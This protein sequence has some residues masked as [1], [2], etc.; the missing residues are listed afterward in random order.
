METQE[1]K[2]EITPPGLIQALKEG[3]NTVANHIGLILLPVLLDIFIW[4]GPRLRLEQLLTPMVEQMTSTL[5][6]VNTADMQ[7]MVA[8]ATET[9]EI[10]LGQLNLTN[11]LSTFPIGLPSLMKGI[12]TNQSP[13]GAP[14]MIEMPTFFGTVLTFLGFATIGIILGG[15]YFSAIS[16]RTAPE[17]VAL[18]LPKIIGQVVNGFVLTIILILILMVLALP[19]FFVISIIALFSPAISQIVLLGASFILLWILVPLVFSPHGMYVNQ[20]SA[21]RAILASI[22]M[23]RAFLPGVGMF[24]LTVILLA[25]GLDVLWQAAPAASWL[26]L[27]G[28]TGHAFIYTAILAASFAYYRQGQAWI[29]ENIRQFKK[30]IN[31]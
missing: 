2:V 13:L 4:L 19:T 27:V 11:S 5:S 20:L 3:F 26:T 28:I 22:Q 15:L 7:A 25:R 18:D 17:P 14:A 8:A 23:V 9:W 12:T 21:P 31:V 10:L 24:L 30:S 6:A 1:T 16:R 29:K